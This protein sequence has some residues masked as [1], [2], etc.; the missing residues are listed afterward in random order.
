VSEQSVI[1]RE[2]GCTRQEFLG[3][4]PGATGGAPYQVTGD[5]ITV[6]PGAGVVRIRIVEAAP[7]RLGLLRLPVLRVSM[8]FLG[9]PVAAR[10]EFL[11]HFDLF[12]RRG[13]G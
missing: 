6:H 1:H 10:A 3:W 13:G 5:L 9:L 12:T 2:M 7:R 8:C 11:R 4:L